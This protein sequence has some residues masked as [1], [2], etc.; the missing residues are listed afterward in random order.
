MIPNGSP[1]VVLCC[2]FTGPAFGHI[3]NDD[4]K[5]IAWRPGGIRVGL[6]KQVKQVKIFANSQLSPKLA[7]VM[8]APAGTSWQRT[9]LFGDSAPP[10]K[11]EPSIETIEVDGITTTHF[12]LEISNNRESLSVPVPRGV[13]SDFA[14]HSVTSLPS[15]VAIYDRYS[16]VLD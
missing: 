5:G 14:L 12:F 8:I 3:M 9:I 10:F 7:F 6:H 15:G 1:Q 13:S 4:G 2:R 16:K 11:T